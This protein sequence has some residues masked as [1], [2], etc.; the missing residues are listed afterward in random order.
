MPRGLIAAS[1][2]GTPTTSANAWPIKITDGTDVVAVNVDGKLLT[3]P[4]PDNYQFYFHAA[5]DMPG[6]VAANTFLSIFNPIGSGKTISFFSVAPDSYATGSSGTA[7]SLL[8]DRITAASAGTQISAANINKLITTQSNSISEVRTGNPTITK[9]GIPLYSWPPPIATG[10]GAVSSAYSA[11]PPGQGFFCLPGQ[12][13][14]FSTS[15]GNVN[16]VWSIK[17]TW[18]EF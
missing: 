2:Q 12:G 1:Q 6:V 8:V 16:Q 7:T 15:A 5:F 4:V 14:A 11:V 3:A 10:A 18:A 17:V 13:I 9:T